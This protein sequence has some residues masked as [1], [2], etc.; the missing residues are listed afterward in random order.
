[1]NSKLG[2]TW[3]ESSGVMTYRFTLA[4]ERRQDRQST[5]RPQSKTAAHM[6]DDLSHITPL[7]M[8]PRHFGVGA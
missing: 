6:E 7:M 8:G 4:W 1:M 2:L 3:R 5:H